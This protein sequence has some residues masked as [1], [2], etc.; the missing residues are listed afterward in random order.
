MLRVIVALL[1]FP[2]ARPKLT[3]AASM[4]SVPAFAR[5]ASARPAAR[6]IGEPATAP[7]VMISTLLMS[8]GFQSRCSFRSSAATP[9]TCGAAIDVPVIETSPPPR[10]AETI[11]DPGAITSGFIASDAG[12]GPRQLNDATAPAS[13][14]APTVI[15]VR[16]VPGL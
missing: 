13:S 10:R 11:C 6:A 3:P 8:T 1:V 5:A 15:A 4:N 9:A 2:D 14:I 16:A 7:A 12:D